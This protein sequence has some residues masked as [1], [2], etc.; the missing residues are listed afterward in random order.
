MVSGPLF[1]IMITL[2]IDASTQ[3]ITGLLYDTVTGMELASHSINYGQRLPAYGAEHGSI[4]FE[5]ACGT[6]YLASPLMWLDGLDLLLSELK[7]QGAPL[8]K[9]SRVAGTCQQHAT[10]Y[11]NDQF[12]SAL[13]GLSAHASLSSQ[14]AGALAREMSPIWMDNT[15]GA[16]CDEITQ[17][18]GRAFVIKTTGSP[19]TARFSGPQIRKFSKT[20]AYAGT[21]RIDMGSSFLASVLAGN[22]APLDFT[23]ASGMNLLDLA[24][25]DWSAAMLEA[26]APNLLA[27]LP[28]LSAPTQVFGVISSYFTEKYGFSADCELLP[29][30]GDNPASLVGMGAT[31]PG[32][33]VLSLGT[34]FTMFAAVANPETDPA[35]YGHLFCHPFGGYMALTCFSNGALTN[36]HLRSK[37]GLDWDAFNALAAPGNDVPAAINPFLIDE[38]TPPTKANASLQDPAALADDDLIRKVLY[39]VFENIRMHTEWISGSAEVI[40]VT[41]GASRSENILAT[42]GKVFGK[43]VI[44]L[45]NPG[46]AALGAAI[47]AGRAI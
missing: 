42:I 22:P 6:E 39:A 26:T 33:M 40:H 38:I 30:T 31:S 12:E 19:M 2:G 11:L 8:D 23:D 1:I 27:R 18:C 4:A 34:S 32:R 45:E 36:E 15:T 3:S 9:V 14:L 16:E 46:S 35:G 10:V 47:I 41:G 37:L 43:E 13:A 24:S 44:R 25:L 28:V 29:W 17:A 5:S 21:K 7:E 20:P